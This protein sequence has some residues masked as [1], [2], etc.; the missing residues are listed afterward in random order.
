VC[1]SDFLRDV[2]VIGVEGHIHVPD[3]ESGNDIALHERRRLV[4]LSDGERPASLRRF[5]LVPETAQDATA[6]WSAIF[7]ADTVTGQEESFALELID[8]RVHLPDRYLAR[9]R[10]EINIRQSARATNHG[11]LVELPIRADD[12]SDRPANTSFVLLVSFFHAT[13]EYGLPLLPHAKYSVFT[14]MPRVPL[15]LKRIPQP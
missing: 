14:L 6:A 8:D 15:V 12:L 1:S 5:V 13:N 7:P 9:L 2:A 11:D 3:I 10:V 4:E